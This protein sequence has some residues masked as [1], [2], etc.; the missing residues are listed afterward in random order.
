MATRLRALSIAL[1]TLLA[2]GCS[3]PPGP[4]S[5]LNTGNTAKGSRPG[6]A[7]P[8]SAEERT[9]TSL[10]ALDVVDAKT[11]FAWGTNDEGF[12]GSVVLKTSDGGAHWTCV[13]RATESELVGL[14]FVDASNGAAISDGGIVFSTSD[15]GTTWTASNDR[16]ILTQRYSFGSNGDAG[17]NGIAFVGDKEGWAFGSRETTAT[18]AKA[19]SVASETHPLV[20]RTTDGGASW[21][22]VRLAA[23]A[24]AVELQR[25]MFFDAQNGWV[26]GGSTEDDAVG[27]V[28]RT[29]DGGA[30]WRSMSPSPKQVPEDVTFVD[31]THGWLVA[32]G[33]DDTGDPGPSEIYATTDGGATWRSA[34]KL[35]AT[36]HALR[37]ADATTGW[38]AGAE[39]KIFATTDG[40]STWTE[41]TAQDWSG[42][43]VIEIAEAQGAATTTSATFSRFALVGPGHGWASADIGLYEYRA[44]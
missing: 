11:A 15:G 29:T 7:P 30:T 6:S 38:A 12:V 18:G 22:E 42:G 28:L 20:V 17:A 24:P 21:K 25:G 14:D 40:G 35:P 8:G 43:Q 34:A 44:K 10:Y 2:V 31:A 26:V 3:E 27:A 1:L 33:V 32:T 23:D 16:S 19:G 39:G 5:A 41:Q 4:K 36:A 9:N 13:L 37:F